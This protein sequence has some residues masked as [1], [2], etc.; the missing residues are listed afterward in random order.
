MAKLELT[1][2]LKTPWRMPC[3]L[4]LGIVVLNI[5]SL[6]ECLILLRKGKAF[7]LNRNIYLWNHLLYWT[8]IQS[9]F[10][11]CLVELI[12]THNLFLGSSRS[13]KSKV[14]FVLGLEIDEQIW[15]IESKT[16]CIVSYLNL[17]VLSQKLINFSR[18]DVLIKGLALPTNYQ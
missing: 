1:I 10:R 2:F 6:I 5:F 11:V 13:N 8:Y 16:V 9:F 12:R 4:W 14:N 3:L 17:E 18:L 15:M 7:L